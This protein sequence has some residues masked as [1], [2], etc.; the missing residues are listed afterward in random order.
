MCTTW[1]HVIMCCCVIDFCRVFFFWVP[2]IISL[3][4]WIVIGGVDGVGFVGI[5]FYGLG[6]LFIFIFLS[7]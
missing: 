1:V 2:M 4:D 3:R 6:F 5:C 7:F